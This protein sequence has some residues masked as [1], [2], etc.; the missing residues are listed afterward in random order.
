LDLIA[1]TRI[2]K[3][4]PDEVDTGDRCHLQTIDGDDFPLPLR[5]A[6]APRRDLAPAAGRGA[7]ID[8]P[9]A[10]LEQMVLVVDLD[11]LEGGATAKTLALGARHVGVVELP[12]EPKLR[13]QRA[14]LTR[15]DSDLE[16]TLAWGG[17]H[18]AAGFGLRLRATIRLGRTRLAIP[19]PVVAHHLHQHAFAQPAVGDPQPLTGKRAADGVENCATGEHEVGALGADAGVGDT[20]FVAP[21]QQTFDHARHFVVDHPAA[22]D[23]AALVTSELEVHTGDRG[24]RTRRAEH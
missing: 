11:E 5:A 8:H 3:I 2:E 7:E 1:R 12:L 14:A 23:A 19:H 20:I 16:R 21:A 22:I 13:R 6:D 9:H 18:F 15:F 17:V 10:W 4:A 24:Y